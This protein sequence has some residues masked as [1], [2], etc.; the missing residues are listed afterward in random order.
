MSSVQ[1]VCSKCGKRMSVN[2]RYFD[3]ELKCTKCGKPFTVTSPEKDRSADTQPV[4][5]TIKCPF[6]A[7]EIKIEAIVCKHCNRDLGPRASTTKGLPDRYG[8]LLLVPWILGVA[9]VYFYV[10]QS[11]RILA[12]SR[13]ATVSVLVLGA[14]AVL[15]GLDA[16]HIR[17]TKGK[18]VNDWSVASWVLGVVLVAVI[19]VPVYG[20][21]RGK[22]EDV[23][24][25]GF[26]STLL[27][28]TFAGFGG[29]TLVLLFGGF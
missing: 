17:K 13:L 19:V 12:A 24:G 8:F 21:K 6:C 27:M 20:Y 28:L 23:S 9:M 22:I 14:A 25:L 2:E 29:F 3:R 11:P 26:I 4:L 10:W 1:H 15:T 16:S 5:D 18:L 7:E